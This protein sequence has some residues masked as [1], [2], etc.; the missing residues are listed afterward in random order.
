LYRLDS[1]SIAIEYGRRYTPCI[2]M[3]DSRWPDQSAEIETTRTSRDESGN[4]GDDYSYFASALSA[5]PSS[6]SEMT[7][8]GGKHANLFRRGTGRGGNGSRRVSGRRSRIENS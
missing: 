6:E 2:L 1:L 3:R 5:K 7:V 4:P 8:T